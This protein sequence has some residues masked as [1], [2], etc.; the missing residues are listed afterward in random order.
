VSG[1]SGEE[2]RRAALAAL[3]EHAD[4]RARE[5]LMHASVAVVGAAGWEGSGGPVEAHRVLLGVDARTLG[6]LRAAPAVID[7]LG[8]ALAAAMAA[9]RGDALLDL[10]LLWSHAARPSAAGYRDAPPPEPEAS[11]QAALV[12][13]LE[14]GGEHL[15]AGLLE[16]ASLDA[17][18]P[19]L[20]SVSLV[21][22]ARDE[23]RAH[24]RG[25]AVITAAL[26]DL[27]A[28]ARARVRVR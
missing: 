22:S 4:E 3:G 15:V 10:Q 7:A 20:V 1:W 21:G 5:T 26:R 18:S 17:S 11:L 19:G 24:P 13:Y 6:G 23:L 25:L 16:G 8:A 2:L 9:R 28:D 14:G 27:T 12:D